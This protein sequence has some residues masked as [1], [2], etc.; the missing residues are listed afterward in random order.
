VNAPVD[1]T[2]H[3][4]LHAK[5]APVAGFARRAEALHAQGESLEA[6]VLLTAGARRFPGDVTALLVLA[7]V[8][9]DSGRDDEAHAWIDQALRIDPACPAALVFFAQRETREMPPPK[10]PVM[11]TPVATPSRMSPRVESASVAAVSPHAFAA[12]AADEQ[13][14]ELEIEEDS[15]PHVATVTLAEIY[16]QQG[17]KEQA[18]QIYRQL[19]ERQPDDEAAQKRLQEILREIEES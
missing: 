10:K 12:R 16:L 6:L 3:G 8:C 17:L 5:D 11:V 13:D 18:A 19:V 4:T 15:A 9:R 1:I 2:A 14:E 7:R